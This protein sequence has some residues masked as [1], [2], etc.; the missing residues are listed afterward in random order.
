ME[1]IDALPYIDRDYHGEMKEKVDALVELEM[2]RNQKKDIDGSFKFSEKI[3]N[4]IE[5]VLINKSQKIGG[6]SFERYNVPEMGDDW[7]GAIKNAKSQY[8]NIRNNL[9]NLELLDKYGEE[10][11]KLHNSQLESFLDELKRRVEMNRK[12]IMRING[13]RKRNQTEAGI[14]INELEEQ[15]IEIVN[16]IILVEKQIKKDQKEHF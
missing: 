5:R 13:E 12:E 16:G 10:I 8:E 11:W 7:E 4:E 9:M 14:I 15:W 1:L 2:K 6:L 3:E